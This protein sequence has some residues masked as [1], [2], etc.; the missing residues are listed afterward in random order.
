MEAKFLDALLN[1]KVIL[2]AYYKGTSMTLT[3]N[4]KQKCDEFKQICESQILLGLRTGVSIPTQ[5][6]DYFEQLNLME[7]YLFD[8]ERVYGSPLTKK[9]EKKYEL[10]FSTRFNMNMEKFQSLWFANVA[11]LLKLK[12]LKDDDMNGFMILNK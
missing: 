10:R 11:S 2:S 4:N 5:I 7:Q 1:H 6:A 9:E 3:F 8:D 12:Q